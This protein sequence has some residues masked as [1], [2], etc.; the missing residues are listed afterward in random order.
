MTEEK[1]P[2]Q[3]KVHYLFTIREEWAITAFGDD[4]LIFEE[5][6]KNGQEDCH[7]SGAASLIDGKWVIDED[8]KRNVTMYSYEDEADLIEAY[9]NKHGLPKDESGKIVENSNV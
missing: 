2:Y 7:M 5:T 8:S 4:W 1:G 6:R 9:L 3:K